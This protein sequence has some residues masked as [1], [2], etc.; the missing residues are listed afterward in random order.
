MENLEKLN[1]LDFIITGD[2]ALAFYI[3]KDDPEKLKENIQNI[4]QLE[5]ITS[6]E[7]ELPSTIINHIVSPAFFSHLYHMAVNIQDHKVS[8]PLWLNIHY[9]RTFN[10]ESALNDEKEHEKYLMITEVLKDYTNSEPISETESKTKSEPQSINETYEL[11]REIVYIFEKYIRKHGLIVCGRKAQELTSYTKN[12]S[13]IPFF[14]LLSKRPSLVTSMITGEIKHASSQL[15]DCSES[16]PKIYEIYDMR[17]GN[18]YA[19]II[20]EKRE[21]N[22]IEINGYKVANIPTMS[23]ILGTCS[24]YLPLN[25]NKSILEK[26]IRH[27]S[28]IYIS[29]LNTEN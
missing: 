1:H 25:I 17:S 24:I 12:N 26:Y 11:S 3:H 28:K 16:S 5:I 13:G 14:V 6:K 7:I 27:L 10:N 9:L 22:Y 19:Y 23:Y 21:A 8:C 15:M 18:V 20:E 2:V 4:E 29:L